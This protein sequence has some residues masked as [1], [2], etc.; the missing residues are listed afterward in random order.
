MYI[1]IC[2]YIYIYTHVSNRGLH[3]VSVTRFPSFRTQTLENL[4]HYLWT[5][6][7][8]WATQTL[9]KVLWAGIL[10]WRPGVHIILPEKFYKLPAVLFCY[11]TITIIMIYQTGTEGGATKGSHRPGSPPASQRASHLEVMHIQITIITMMI[12]MIMILLL[13]LLIIII[14]IIIIMMKIVI[15][16]AGQPASQPPGQGHARE[17]VPGGQRRHLSMTYTRFA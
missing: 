2:V 15:I 7:G 5:K 13:L 11:T 16:P 4:S 8:S 9:A 12:I 10:L 6:M 17:R 14:I 1:C 3:P